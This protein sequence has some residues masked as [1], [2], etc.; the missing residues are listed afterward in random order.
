MALR[1]IFHFVQ[2]DKTRPRDHRLGDINTQH[3]R[4]VA[5]SSGDSSCEVELVEDNVLKTSFHAPDKAGWG[6]EIPGK[7]CRRKHIPIK[8]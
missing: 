2:N 3:G 6:G 1:E 4:L 7:R 5:V 8:F